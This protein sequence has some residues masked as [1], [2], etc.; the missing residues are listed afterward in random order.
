MAFYVW[1]DLPASVFI[2]RADANNS[3]FRIAF[4]DI[5]LHLRVREKI[6]DKMKL[7]ESVWTS[8]VDGLLVTFVVCVPGAEG[9]V[10]CCAAFEGPASSANLT[11]GVVWR[12]LLNVSLFEFDILKSVWNEWAI[13]WKIKVFGYD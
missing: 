8:A 7:N 11:L 12:I 5:K 13:A 3:F 1:G 4:L 6:L 10:V 9:V 2:V